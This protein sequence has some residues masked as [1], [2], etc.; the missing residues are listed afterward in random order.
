MSSAIHASASGLP[1]AIR[2]ITA[3]GDEENAFR[4][5]VDV[6]LREIPGA[7]AGGITE[8]RAGALCT[9]AVSHPDVRLIDHALYESGEGPCLSAALAE[10]PV[11][12]SNEVDTDPR[13]HRFGHAA[14]AL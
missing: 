1:D 3:D 12:V 11:V 13:W 4:R 7:E 10:M 9:R 8:L 14:A 6:A 5:V 2:T